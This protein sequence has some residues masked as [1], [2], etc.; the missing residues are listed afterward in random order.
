MRIGGGRKL[1]VVLFQFLQNE[2]IDAIPKSGRFALHC[3]HGGSLWR[4]E[5]PMLLVFRALGDPALEQFLL[6]RCENL[7]RFRRRHDFILIVGENARDQI[8]F[9]RFSRNDGA[10]LNGV[11]TNVQAQILLAMLLIGPVAVITIF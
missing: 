8:A 11:S 6:F 4:C 2:R 9:L 10:S 3:R 7:M 5:G 1:R